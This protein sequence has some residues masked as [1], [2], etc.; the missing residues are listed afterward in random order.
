MFSPVIKNSSIRAL[1]RIVAR[2]DLKLEQL[3]VKMAFLYRK[4]EDIYIQRPENFVASEREDHVC[5]LKK[6]L[7]ELKQSPK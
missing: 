2:H 6:S 7:C 5:L 1:L 4:L 3:D